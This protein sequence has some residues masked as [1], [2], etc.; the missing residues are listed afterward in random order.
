[1]LNI[2]IEQRYDGNVWS[3]S[4]PSQYIEEI[5]RK[6][7]NYKKFPVFV[8]MVLTSLEKKSESVFIDIL[9]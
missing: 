8:K 5:T 6:T 3:N 7:G 1:M 4:Y 9:T 2:Q